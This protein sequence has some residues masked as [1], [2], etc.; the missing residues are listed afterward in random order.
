MSPDAITAAAA[1]V[2]LRAQY[3]PSPGQVA[4][5]AG[6]S[7][8]HPLEPRGEVL[9]LNGPCAVLSP[10]DDERVL[11]AAGFQVGTLSDQL[12]PGDQWVVVG[13]GEQGG[14][15]ARHVR[16]G[17]IA[18]G[19]D[20]AGEARVHDDGRIAVVPDHL[21]D[22]FPDRHIPDADLAFLPPP[23]NLQAGLADAA[24]DG[25]PAPAASREDHL[26]RYHP[27]DPIYPAPS[28]TTKQALLAQPPSRRRELILASLEELATPG[29]RPDPS[30]AGQAA[31]LIH[32]DL[33][34]RD[35]ICTDVFNDRER[36]EA[37]LQL[38][39]GADPTLRYGLAGAAAVTQYVTNGISLAPGQ[40]SEDNPADTMAGLINQAAS[41]GIPPDELRA[42]LTDGIPDLKNLDNGWLLEQRTR[43]SAAFPQ[44]ARDAL[45]PRSSAQPNTSSTRS[46]QQPEQSQDSGPE[47]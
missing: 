2:P 33:N 15:T 19:A 22:A 10:N 17:L 24:Y 16:D 30:R 18:S 3:H 14:Q 20:I 45:A 47:R 32:S 39:R 42:V 37:L 44:P 6:T 8:P 40:I 27:T 1:Y 4:V 41:N 36:T 25:R 34:L 35:R 43:A 11:R 31:Y 7:R 38:Y 46:M 9:E 21:R 26:A 29:H 12:A 23:A 28:A 13:Y 5:I